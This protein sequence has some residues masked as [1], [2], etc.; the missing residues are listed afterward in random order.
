VRIH[1][2]ADRREQ[3]GGK[4]V[5]QRVLATLGQLDALGESGKLD[6]LARSMLKFT[7]ALE[8]LDAHRTDELDAKMTLN[9]ADEPKDRIV[10]HAKKACVR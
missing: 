9:A 4:V 10:A 1:L 8:V 6:D 2:P 5:R 3:K 7:K